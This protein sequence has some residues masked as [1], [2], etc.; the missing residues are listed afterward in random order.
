M[1]VFGKV[2]GA[3]EGLFKVGNT[4]DRFGKGEVAAG[5]LGSVDGVDGGMTA[6]GESSLLRISPEGDVF[7]DVITSVC[8]FTN[9]GFSSG[10]GSSFGSR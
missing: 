9:K 7:P 10:L 5:E 2:E 4:A 6:D 8:V 1:T 3:R